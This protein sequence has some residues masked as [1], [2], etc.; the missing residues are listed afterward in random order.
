MIGPGS[1]LRPADAAAV[2]AILRPRLELLPIAAAIWVAWAVPVVGVGVDR[3]VVAFACLDAAWAHLRWTLGVGLPAT[4]L[5]ACLFTVAADQVV[6][7]ADR[8]PGVFDP[9]GPVRNALV[10][11]TAAAVA[12]FY[13]A[14]YG[15][16]Y[17]AVG[18]VLF[19]SLYAP[20]LALMPL[21]A[22]QTSAI[23]YTWGPGVGALWALLYAGAVVLQVGWWYV[24]AYGAARLRSFR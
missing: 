19:A 15:A 1:G 14:G 12:L 22:L 23:G 9:P 8:L 7:P 18:G 17:T 4:Y 10:A 16:L 11:V 2:R 24:L 3:C 20:I 21:F 6:Q 13:L 5:A